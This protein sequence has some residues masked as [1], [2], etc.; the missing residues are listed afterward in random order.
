MGSAPPGPLRRH[1]PVAQCTTPPYSIGIQRVRHAAIGGGGVCCQR[2]GLYVVDADGGPAELLVEGMDGMVQAPTFSPDGTKIAY[3][4]GAGDHSN[5]VWVMNADGSDAHEIV[6][7]AD[8]V[9]HVRGLQWSPVADR[10]A[11]GLEG[12]TYTFAPDGSDFTRVIAE[13][14]QPYWSPDGSQL[15]YTVACVPSDVGCGLAIAD[16]DGSNMV[17]FGMYTSGPWHPGRLT[18]SPGG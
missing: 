13:G 2:Y 18:N 8:V 11:L 17:R 6:S 15:A 1:R 9:G 7:N 5:S 16:A 4:Y 14:N 12:A 3:T 10:I